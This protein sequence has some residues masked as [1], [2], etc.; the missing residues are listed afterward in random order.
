MKKELTAS[1]LEG[2]ISEKKHPVG[3][4]NAN[5]GKKWLNAK[6][7]FQHQNIANEIWEL[8]M[9]GGSADPG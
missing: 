3:A 9:Q 7:F 6:Y 2:W 4:I 5:L 1:E 8:S